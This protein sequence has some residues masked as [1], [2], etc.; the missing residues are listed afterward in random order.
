MTQPPY[1]LIA[2]GMGIRIYDIE[3]TNLY[4]LIT[5]RA[6]PVALSFSYRLNY[7]FWSDV[8]KMKIS[9]TNLTNIS[10]LVGS[11]ITSPEGI[12]FDWVDNILYWTDSQRRQIERIHI[13]SGERAV[14]IANLDGPQ[15]IVLDPRQHQR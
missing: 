7:F 9:L 10:V 11:N 4:S 8:Q 1:L 2:S 15:A 12:A 6:T 13:E 14:V 3:S 5:G